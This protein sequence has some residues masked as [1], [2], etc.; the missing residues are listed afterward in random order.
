[1]SQ[2][3]WSANLFEVGRHRF[4]RCKIWKQACPLDD[5]LSL[6]TTAF[7]LLHAF[8]PAAFTV[9]LATLGAPEREG[10]A[11]EARPA[12]IFWER[13]PEALLLPLSFKPLFND[14]RR[15]LGRR[16][17]I[18]LRDADK[19]RLVLWRQSDR[20][21]LGLLVHGDALPLV[22]NGRKV[23]KEHIAFKVCE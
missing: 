6:A 12:S 5:F 14:N 2:N 19:L 1:M 13:G 11:K 16:A 21:G 9:R 3:G 18:G 22:R 15:K 8:V 23:Y 17:L 20:E 4:V 7:G 10:S